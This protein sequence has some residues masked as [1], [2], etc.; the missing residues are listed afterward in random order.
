MLKLQAMH[1]ILYQSCRKEEHPKKKSAKGATLRQKQTCSAV[2][3][4]DCWL[5]I[6]KSAVFSQNGAFTC[7]FWAS[8][9]AVREQLA[10]IALDL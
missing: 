6:S 2:S 9:L 1:S 5:K 7:C 10:P 4:V 3:R 8:F